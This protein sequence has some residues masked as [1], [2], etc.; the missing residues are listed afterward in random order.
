MNKYS[1][2]NEEL[3]RRVKNGDTDARNKLIE[4]NIGLV[5]SIVKRFSGRGHEAEDLFQ[6]GCIGLI[7]AVNKFDTSYGVAFST[8]A[9]PMIIGEIKRFIRDDG[10]IKVSRSLKTIACKAAQIKEKMY[11][12]NKTEPT[13][14]MIA[15]ELGITP[16]ELAAALEA[17]QRPE[18]L[19][20]RTDDGNSENKPLLDRLKTDAEYEQ[21]VE[22]RLMLRQAFC[23]MD[24]RERLIIYMRYFRQ[25]T[26]TEIAAKLGISQVQVSRLE[27]KALSKMREKL[28]G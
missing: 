3:L 2:I 4:L 26:Q 27:K 12:E 17:S 13:V 24:E 22:N 23:G 10:I 5:R 9:V 14:A 28:S 8:Y 21:S 11:A 15:K 16:Q 7:K 19:Y 25:K 1:E 18:S 6:I 20:A